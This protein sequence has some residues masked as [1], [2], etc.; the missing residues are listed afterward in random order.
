MRHF[1]DEL[2]L[3][4]SSMNTSKT[5]TVNPMLNEWAERAAP[6]LDEYLRVRR[7]PSAVMIFVDA[8]GNRVQIS[9]GVEDEA[10][11]RPVGPTTLY[12]VGSITKT[13]VA[14]ALLRCVREGRCKLDDPIDRHLPWATVDGTTAPTIEQL[15]SHTSGLR[16]G[17]FVTHESNLEAVWA[18][19]ARAARPP[20]GV[21]FYYSNTAF[22]LLGATL[23]TLHGASLAEVLARE[24]FQPLGMHQTLGAI[25]NSARALCV[26]G[27]RGA[28]DDSPRLSSDALHE[29]PWE[30]ITG[31]SGCVIS[32]AHDMAT[33]VTS[34]LNRLPTLIDSSSF[35]NLCRPRV[36]TER[37]DVDYALGIFSIRGTTDTSPVLGHTGGM[38]GYCC[39]YKADMEH[40]YGYMLLTNLGVDHQSS[41]G[42][43]L[44]NLLLACRPHASETLQLPPI[45]LQL[46]DEARGRY[47]DGVLSWCIGGDADKPTLEVAGNVVALEACDV[48]R[49]LVHH[50]SLRTYELNLHRDESGSIAGLDHGATYLAKEGHAAPGSASTFASPC[51]QTDNHRA[52]VGTY[53]SRVV[54]TPVLR[55]LSVRGK[56]QMRLADLIINLVEREPGCFD[57][58]GT[59]EA[60]EFSEL[61]WSGPAGSQYQMV[62][63]S[64]C[65][66]YRVNPHSVSAGEDALAKTNS[67]A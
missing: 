41:A 19:R 55:L 24:V 57:V 11:R 45:A 51:P 5:A 46:P 8:Q 54:W 3:G 18:L 16:T 37:D 38:M 44:D 62:T 2:N 59:P 33:F 39:S 30:V 26:R 31:G 25:T 61:G 52:Y 27:H 21:S 60:L 64:G 9:R 49:Y 53:R 7:T 29:A 40:G 14:L 20:N 4:T 47:S 34:L 66:F 15:L 23:E 36:V 17:T 42:S 1:G 10:S 65:P 12:Q 48:D 28:M 43:R 22:D 56:L 50:A 58:D 35:D 6:L 13:F 67:F 32:N 63:G